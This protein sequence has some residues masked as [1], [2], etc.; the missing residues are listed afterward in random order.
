[1][2]KQYIKLNKN[3]VVVQKQ[4]YKSRGFIETDKNP[5]CGQIMQPDGSFKSPP[6]EPVPYD[7]LRRSDYPTIGDQLDALWKVI[8]QMR[9]DGLNIPQDAD[10]LLGQILAVKKKYPK[11][12]SVE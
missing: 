2:K 10:D 3:N 4:P 5:V 1:M 11:P 7:V 12:E 8:N 6:K 9:L